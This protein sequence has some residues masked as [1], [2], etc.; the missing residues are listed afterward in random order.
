MERQGVIRVRGEPVG[1][2]VLVLGPV[3]H[4]VSQV[5]APVPVA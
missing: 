3:A 2:F 5:G 1:P 4:P